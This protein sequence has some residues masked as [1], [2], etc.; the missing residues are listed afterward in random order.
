MR[1][2]FGCAA[3][4]RVSQADTHRRAAV[5]VPHLREAVPRAQRAAAPPHGDARASA[6][7]HVHRLLQ[8]LRQLT[9]PETTPAHPHRGAT[10]RVPPLRETVRAGRLLT[11]PP[12]NT[13]RAIPASVRRVWSE[14]PNTVWAG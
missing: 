4:V 2:E 1:E 6:P 5:R 7:A 9:K 10:V 12:E 3:H 8:G 11:R 14:V 13:F